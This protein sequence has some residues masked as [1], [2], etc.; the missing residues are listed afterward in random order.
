MQFLLHGFSQ[1]S[2]DTVGISCFYNDLKFLGG[3]IYSVTDIWGQ[4]KAFRCLL[5]KAMVAEAAD[6]EVDATV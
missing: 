1:T 5:A 2:Y 4:K 3:F 6:P